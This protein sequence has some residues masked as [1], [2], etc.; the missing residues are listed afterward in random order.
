MHE[1]A[2]WLSSLQSQNDNV[3]SQTDPARMRVANRTHE[4]F[5]CLGSITLK[6]GVVFAIEPDY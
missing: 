1:M 5:V 4:T 6:A 3:E 2:Q